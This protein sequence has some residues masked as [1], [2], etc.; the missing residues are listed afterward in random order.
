MKEYKTVINLQGSFYQNALD[1]CCCNKK[2]DFASFQFSKI[3]I[4]S[5]AT[6]ILTR[7]HYRIRISFPVGNK[8][9]PSML[10]SNVFRRGG[11]VENEEQWLYFIL[12][13]WP[14]YWKKR[15]TSCLFFLLLS[16][17]FFLNS[18]DSKIIIRVDLSCKFI[19]W[20]TVFNLF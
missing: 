20:F 1:F 10:I 15:R 18:L 2:K 9:V 5:P 3:Q 12:Y 13:F 16:R 7:Q 14:T 19:K 8:T 6:P 11:S 4:Y 17:Y